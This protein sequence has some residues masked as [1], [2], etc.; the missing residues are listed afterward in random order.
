MDQLVHQKGIASGYLARTYQ[1]HPMFPCLI[2]RTK[3][4]ELD[5]TV[6]G[7]PTDCT[8]NI[9]FDL[10]NFNYRYVV[11]HKAQP[12]DWY[13]APDSWGQGQAA[14]LI[15]RFFGEQTPLVD[16]DLVTVYRVPP[17]AELT[18]LEP[19]IGLAGNW[20][21]A[22]AEWRWARSPAVLFLSIPEPQN[23]VI[24]FVPAFVYDPEAKA[25]MGQEGRLLVTVDNGY[26]TTVTIRSGEKTAVPLTLDA[27]VYSVRLALEAG[28]FR[29]SDVSENRDKRPLSFAFHLINLL[30]ETP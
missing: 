14:E 10:T 19:T 29:P 1:F 12:G 30:T 4:P 26:S 25:G 8:A 13:D 2:P 3:E 7:Q 6:N 16:D 15:D 17:T 23:V 24:E 5:V 28:N 18:G 22:E 21:E 20:Y 9:L 11:L 27:G